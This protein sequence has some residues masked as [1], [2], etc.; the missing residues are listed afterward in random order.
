MLVVF[1]F[2][3]FLFFLLGDYLMK[4]YDI[5]CSKK[6]SSIVGRCCLIFVLNCFDVLVIS[7][8]VPFCRV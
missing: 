5:L 1:C 6:I 4:I 8:V 7:R 2:F 3:S